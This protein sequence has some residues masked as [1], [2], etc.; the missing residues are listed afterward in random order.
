MPT[1]K[2]LTMKD[3][4]RQHLLNYQ[5]I[6]TFLA[7]LSIPEI[8]Q[9]QEIL[10]YDIFMENQQSKYANTLRLKLEGKA[11]NEFYLRKC[12]SREIVHTH[13]LTMLGGV[14]PSN[15]VA[16]VINILNT[17]RNNKQNDRKLK[18]LLYNYIEGYRKGA[19]SHSTL[20]E[21]ESQEEAGM[22]IL[23][24]LE[25]LKNTPSGLFKIPKRL[26]LVHK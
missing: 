19:V 22:E 13:I 25:L 8:Q 20:R 9:I 7:G 24:E 4:G 10:K 2:R 3:L 23:K 15:R 16:Y 26:T 21:L 5:N 11:V 14:E 6:D 18:R 17:Y 12:P 1:F